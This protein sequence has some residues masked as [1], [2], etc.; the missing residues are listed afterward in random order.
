MKLIVDK[1]I[2]NINQTTTLEQ[3]AKEYF[4]N[5]KIYAGIVNGKL[6]KLLSILK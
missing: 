6:K 2:I 5:Q 1:Q 4:I 3:I